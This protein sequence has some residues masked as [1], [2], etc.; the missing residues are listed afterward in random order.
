MALELGLTLFEIRS[1][2]AADLVVWGNPPAQEPKRLSSFESADWGD[3]AV[4]PERATFL[5]VRK[6]QAGIVV[7]S[8]HHEPDWRKA[9]QETGEPGWFL[10]VD[11]PGKALWKL[12]DGPCRPKEDPD[13]WL[14]EA[15]IVGRFG[16]RARSSTIHRGAQIQENVEIGS[17]CVVHSRV[18][19]GASSRIGDLT[20]LGAPGFGLVS[21][22]DGH[23]ALPHWAG[24]HIGED[25]QIGPQ[26]QVSSGLLDPTTIGGGAR[27]DAQIQVGHNCAIG[28]RCIIAGQVGIAGS[29]SLGEGCLVGGQAGFA[30]HVRL[31]EGCVVAARA[32]VTRSWPPR[33]RLYGFPARP[34]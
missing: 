4:V 22:E 25:V 3:L 6:C 27:L 33:T 7:G 9:R 15:E 23:Q 1:L 19:I 24:V 30:D 10:R 13:D 18:Q 21:G 12:L 28:K 17:G 20:V 14:S 8:A 34:K 31:G 16:K 32:G 29:V 5:M 2:L 11:Q 26:C